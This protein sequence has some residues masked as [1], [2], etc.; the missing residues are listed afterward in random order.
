MPGRAANGLERH[1]AFPVKRSL[2]LAFLLPMRVQTLDV[3]PPDEPPPEF[4][5]EH[6][7][8][9]PDFIRLPP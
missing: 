7:A 1:A 3:R 4:G 5:G 6:E 2:E 8:Q 9:L